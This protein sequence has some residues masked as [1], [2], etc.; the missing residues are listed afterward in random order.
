MQA[1]RAGGV[2]LGLT[3]HLARWL[4]QIVLPAST[5]MTRILLLL[6]T[7]T[8]LSV[9]PVT[10]LMPARTR[11]ISAPLDLLIWMATL[12]PR[13]SRARL[14]RTRRQA[15]LRVRTALRVQS[16]T[17]PMLLL[18]V[19]RVWLESSV[20]QGGLSAKRVRVVVRTTT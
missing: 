4:A 15:R 8:R 5:T 12:P 20:R 17:T 10:T 9:V 18:R 3:R 1:H 11:V 6:V 16:I 2:L 7:T 13:V 14:G 19:C